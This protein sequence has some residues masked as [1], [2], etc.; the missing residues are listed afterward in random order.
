MK[1]TLRGKRHIR[2]RRIVA[3]TRMKKRSKKFIY[4]LKVASRYFSGI[5]RIFQSMLEELKIALERQ[6]SS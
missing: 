6:K 3:V 1:K 4:S 5:G 2:A